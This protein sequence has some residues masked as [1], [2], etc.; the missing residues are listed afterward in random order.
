MIIGDIP[1]Y[2][3]EDS[4]D[5]WAHNEILQL[6]SERR[7]HLLPGV[8]PIIFRRRVSFGET[9]YMI[10]NI[11]NLPGYEWWVRRIKSMYKLCDIVRIDHFRAFSNYFAIPFG[12]ED[13]TNGEW[14]DGPGTDFFDVLR[15]ELIKDGIVDSDEDELL[16]IAED[17]GLID[18]SVRELLKATGLPE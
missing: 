5:A 10:G 2:V 17:L 16:I 3:A 6:D 1:I 13:A 7:R 9:R 4:A 12:D 15:R 14:Q 11:L 18:D 8:L